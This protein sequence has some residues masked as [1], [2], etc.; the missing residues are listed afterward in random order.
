MLGWLV[1]AV[2]LWRGNLFPQ[3]VAPATIAGIIL[4]PVL[5]VTPLGVIGQVMGNVVFGLGL[6][7]L[8]YSLL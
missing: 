2:S 3:C 5:G 4:I 8:G 7:G 1:L 6:I